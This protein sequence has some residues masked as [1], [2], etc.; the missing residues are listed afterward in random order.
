MCR[1]PT[2]AVAC[3]S[4]L[5]PVSALPIRDLSSYVHIRRL[6]FVPPPERRTENAGPVA[7]VCGSNG[8][9]VSFEGAD[10]GNKEMC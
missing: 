6:I 1:L 8:R 2:G 3:S 9:L 7:G 4:A 5:N 10:P